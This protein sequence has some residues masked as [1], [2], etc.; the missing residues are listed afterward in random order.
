[1][2]RARHGRARP[3]VGRRKAT[4]GVVTGVLTPQPAEMLPHRLTDGSLW[5]TW[6]RRGVPGG[7]GPHSVAALY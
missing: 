6:W 2:R 3:V 1:V 7:R 4:Q 5:S